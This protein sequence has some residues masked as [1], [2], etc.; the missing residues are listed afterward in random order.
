MQS[1]SP[2]SF[3]CRLAMVNAVKAA[4][5]VTFRDS[6][7]DKVGD[8][9][10][11][12]ENGDKPELASQV[13][14]S[15]HLVQLVQIIFAFVLGQGLSDNRAALL[16]PLHNLIPLLA[17]LAVFITTILS[18]VGW[19]ELMERC[20]YVLWTG[21][22]RPHIVELFRLGVDLL[23]V[24]TYAV[25]LF[26]VGELTKNDA[27]PLDLYVLGFTMLYGFYVLHALLTWATYGRQSANIKFNVS[28]A[29]GFA[30]LWGIYQVRY[31]LALS[32]GWQAGVNALTIVVI[33]LAVMGYRWKMGMRV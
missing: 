30:A 21:E 14:I 9:V 32:H 22:G 24:A 33:I 18:W 2:R 15:D 25:L 1:E 13:D 16:S 4:L 27:V 5:G 23:I 12:A 6:A 26:F 19:H 3:R 7:G 11:G 29:V 8:K 20:P 17:L 28:F 10:N 31:E